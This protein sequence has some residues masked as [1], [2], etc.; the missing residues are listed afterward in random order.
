MKTP[1]VFIIFNRPD[2]TQRV[3]DAIRRAR[4][5]QLLLISD[6]P[7]GLRPG[8]QEKVTQVR[9]IVENIDWECEIFKNYS[10]LNLGCKNRVS[11]GISWAFSIV[12][13][14]I[15][16]EDDC[17][18]HPD[19]FQ[20][21]EELL[22][23]YRDEPRIAQICG[24]NHL[25]TQPQG[26]DSYYF[27]KYNNIWGWASWRR[28]WR[29]YDVSM[30]H[31]A[32]ARRSNP[33]TSWLGSWKANRYWSQIFDQV[34][35]GKIDTWDYQWMFACW[36]NQLLSIVPKNNMIS[37]LGFG[38]DATH[39]L[40]K[41]RFAEQSTESLSIP[42]KHPQCIKINEQADYLAES[43]EYSGSWFQFFKR[44]IKLR[45]P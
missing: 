16:L 2:V 29:H 23:R 9:Q 1:V 8:E 28:A 13:E 37:N 36:M 32:D 12:E 39:T 44:E 15:I 27:S 19:F 40:E 43:I 21:C 7:R 14:A 11:S 31:W 17:L 18:P 10:D 38:P 24:A 34:H 5:P 33:F 26:D 42:L 25:H 35:A 22:I 45:R 3:F 4:P 20:F 41:N 6:G 30:T